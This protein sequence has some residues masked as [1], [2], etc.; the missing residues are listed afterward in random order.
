MKIIITESQYG[1]V[2]KLLSEQRKKYEERYDVPRLSTV[3]IE[4]QNSEGVP[5]SLKVDKFRMFDEYQE[6]EEISNEL[7]NILRE[8]PGSIPGEKFEEV[9]KNTERLIDFGKMLNS[10]INLNIYKDK[11]DNEF[12]HARTSI[13]TDDGRIWVTSYVGSPNVYKGGINDEEANMRG[14]KGLYKKMRKYF[15]DDK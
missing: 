4:L 15:I 11:N 7:H 3:L 8:T 9:L 14:R 1:L 13:L 5:K 10:P 6:M 2:S 12:I